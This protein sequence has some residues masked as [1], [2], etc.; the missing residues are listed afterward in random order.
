MDDTTTTTAVVTNFTANFGIVK[1]NSV[2]TF[3]IV[4]NIIAAT[5]VIAE[6]NFH[7]W[8]VVTKDSTSYSVMSAKSVAKSAADNATGNA[9]DSATA[10]AVDSLIDHCCLGYF[11]RKLQLRPNSSSSFPA[12]CAGP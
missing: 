9:A 1:P 10:S 3:A 8:G 2:A 6:L 5:T 12:A 7:Q 4:V 11:G